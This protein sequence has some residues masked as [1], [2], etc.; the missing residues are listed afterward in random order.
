VSRCF[1]KSYSLDAVSKN[2]KDIVFQ[3]AFNN[4]FALGSAYRPTDLPNGLSSMLVA[5]DLLIG[6]YFV[7]DISN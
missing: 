1:Q 7:V 4:R 5:A 3:F 2:K 6:T